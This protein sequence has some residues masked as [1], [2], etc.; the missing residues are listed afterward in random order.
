LFR[1]YV[2]RRQVN[3]KK[4][5][6]GEQRAKQGDFRQ[7]EIDNPKKGKKN[8]FSNRESRGKKT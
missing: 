6:E 1:K 2:V 5:R 3:K 7:R 8:Q 4:K